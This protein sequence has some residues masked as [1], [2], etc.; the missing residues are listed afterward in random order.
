ME[1]GGGSRRVGVLM[2]L[3]NFGRKSI[4]S[5][6]YEPFLSDSGQQVPEAGG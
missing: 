4:G 6:F 5:V 3:L 1:G 2:V